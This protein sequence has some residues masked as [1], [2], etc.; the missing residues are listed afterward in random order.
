ML[1]P[2][3]PGRSR[4]MV[5]LRL[6]CL[7]VSIAAIAVHAIVGADQWMPKLDEGL[8]G[9][10]YHPIFV[11]MHDQ[12]FKKAADYESFCREHESEKRSVL[13]PRVLQQLRANADKSWERIKAR[14]A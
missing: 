2:F 8:A 1:V 12:L 3:G 13:R 11:R 4:F 5:H 7:V 14:V 10:I 6:L 9:E